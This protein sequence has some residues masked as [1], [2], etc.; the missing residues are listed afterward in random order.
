MF[1][2]CTNFNL[3]IA[4]NFIPSSATNINGIFAYSNIP[5][6]KS[7]NYL[8]RLT[9]AVGAYASTPITSYPA[10]LFANLRNLTNISYFFKDCFKLNMPI[11]DSLFND[12]ENLTNVSSMF[13]FCE[14][15]GAGSSTNTIPEGLFKN[16]LNLENVSSMFEYCV[17]LYG[18]IPLMF[19]NESDSPYTK[20]TN[21]SR[22]FYHAVIPAENNHIFEQEFLYNL[23]SVTNAS[24]MF[25][26]VNS[27]TNVGNNTTHSAF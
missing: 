2:G 26:C 14:W 13:S 12:C 3:P 24:R 23:P 9:S 18:I 5:T 16:N 15:M 27:R 20:L 4:D 10:N 7:L 1:A 6:V 25:F 11:P 8:T 22:M 21:V 17:S 19:K